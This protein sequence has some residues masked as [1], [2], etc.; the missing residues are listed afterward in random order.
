MAT[1]PVIPNRIYDNTLKIDTDK[2]DVEE[3]L[4]QEQSKDLLRFTTAGSVDDG[5][6][7]L[8]GRLL[9]DARGAYEDQLKQAIRG[10][11]I[12]FSLLTDGLVAEIGITYVR[13]DTEEGT[14]H[15][16]N[17]QVLAAAVGPIARPRPAESG[18]GPGEPPPA[19]EP[20]G[21]A[22]D[23]P[24]YGGPPHGSP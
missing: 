23:D 24:P 12:D 7:T 9:H 21:P 16:P 3:F 15:L 22:H 13:L 14:L 20:A 4:R 11:E 18:P 17:S 8:I 5:K 2:F 6:S 1:L 10:G 19:R